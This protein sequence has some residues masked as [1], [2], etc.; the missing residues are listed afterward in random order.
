MAA[1]RATCLVAWWAFAK[2]QAP[3]PLWLGLV[4]AGRA[5]AVNL[6]ELN[7][8]A[9]Q[10]RTIGAVAL[11]SADQYVWQDALRCMPGYCLFTSSAKGAS[12][13]YEVSSANAST[14]F[15]VPIA[16]VCAHMHFDVTSR[17]AFT[18]CDE[19]G[20]WKVWSINSTTGSTKL[21]G[22]MTKSVAGG[23]ILPGQTTHCSA[24]HHLY[25]GVSHG[26]AGKD[27]VLAVSTATGVVDNTTVLSVPLFAALWANC[28]GSG[29]IGGLSYT[30]GAGP[31][32]NATLAFGTVDVRGA[33]TQITQ[34]SLFPG[35]VP[36]GVLTA[37]SDRGP[38]GNYYAAL[39]Y[40]PGHLTNSTGGEGFMWLLDPLGSDPGVDEVSEFSYNLVSASWERS[41]W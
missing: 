10:K 34:A 3:A 12:T 1:F 23:S 40:P 7:D 31:A 4:P 24:T 36:N 5:G 21:I 2:A 11:S 33:Y 18:I 13:V 39:V 25:L 17:T 29:A 15:A 28:D 41:N 20:H 22:D 32:D 6:I 14:A 30:P 38:S 8:D 35:Y 26:G 27:V 16:G 37:T 9:V 19:S